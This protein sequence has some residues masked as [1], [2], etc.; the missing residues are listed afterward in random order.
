MAGEGGS[1]QLCPTCREELPVTLANT[2]CP[3]CGDLLEV[4][5]RAPELSGRALTDLFGARRGSRAPLDASGVWRFR[6]LVFPDAGDDVVTH[7]EGNT[8]L[9]VRPT[10]SRWVGVHELSLKHEGHNPTGSFKDRG[11]TVGVTQA[12][13][14]GARAIACAS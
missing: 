11:M 1:W 3:R 9:L 4:R 6:E 5:H 2:R 14:V 7:P 10:V 13:R 8:P 12:R